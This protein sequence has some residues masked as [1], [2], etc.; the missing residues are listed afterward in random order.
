[1]FLFPNCFLLLMQKF[2]LMPV[3]FLLFLLLKK[4][5]DRPLAG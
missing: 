1:M 4:L 3:F 2:V 5:D